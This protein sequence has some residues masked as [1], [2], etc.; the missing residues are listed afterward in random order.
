MDVLT[1][2]PRLV[3]LIANPAARWGGRW[4]DQ[5]RSAFDRAGVTCDAMITER[6]GHAA[7]LAATHAPRYSAVFTLGGDGTAMEVIGA[8]AHGEVPVGVLPGGT[9][10]LVARA[11]GI[12]LRIERAI[13]ELL[14]GDVATIDLGVVGV[15][16]G[17]ERRFAFAAGVGLDARMV[18]ETPPSLK[19]RLGFVAYALTAARAALS[20]R[21]F[22]ARV[23]VDGVVVERRAVAVMIANFGSVL[24]DLIM[25]GPGILQDDGRLDVCI[26]SPSSNA[27]ALRLAWRMFRRDFRPTES[28]HYLPGRSI[29]IDCDPPQLYQADGEVLGRTPF[30]ARVDPLAIKLLVPHKR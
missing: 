22:T 30:S 19:R 6:P 4:L 13:A 14:D 23:E 15:A 29:R 1:E 21:E 28:L 8:L 11:L 9:G 2:T 7:E 27:D 10:N 20:R 25:L 3:L 12:P 26:I 24:S 17:V 16:G 5:A 18:H